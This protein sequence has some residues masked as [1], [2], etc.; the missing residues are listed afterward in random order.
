MSF[1]RS[2]ERAFIDSAKIA[3]AQTAARLDK[4]EERE[5]KLKETRDALI[6]EYGPE[7]VIKALGSVAEGP[8]EESS[9]IKLPP[10]TD[11]ADG[12]VPVAD[13][14]L[15]RV[16]ENIGLGDVAGLSRLLSRQQ[17]EQDIFDSEARQDQRRRKQLAE[18]RQYDEGQARESEERL[19]QA[20]SERYQNE[21]LDN[22]LRNLQTTT[23]ANQSAARAAGLPLPERSVAT[24]LSAQLAQLPSFRGGG[25][26]SD[27]GQSIAQDLD[28]AAAGQSAQLSQNIISQKETED[29]EAEALRQEVERKKFGSAIMQQVRS[30][31]FETEEQVVD[32]YQ[33]LG[34]EPET[35]MQYFRAAKASMPRDIGAE[36]FDA[37]LDSPMG[38]REGSGAEFYP[39]KSVQRQQVNANP[40]LRMFAE[41]I[42]LSG[43]Q[44][45]S[46]PK[47]RKLFEQQGVGDNAASSAAVLNF[48]QTGNLEAVNNL[49][50]EAQAQ[51]NAQINRL[52][53]SEEI[54]KIGNAAEWG[55]VAGTTSYASSDEFN[56]LWTE[57]KQVGIGKS[58]Q[59]P[60]WTVVP[61]LDDNNIH[62]DKMPFVAVPAPFNVL[63]RNLNASERKAMKQHAEGI[64][65]DFKAQH[66]KGELNTTKSGKQFWEGPPLA[67]SDGKDE[68][69]NPLN[70][71][72]VPP[73]L[74]EE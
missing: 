63:G 33:P 13:E 71:P 2:F 5:R 10:F 9:E 58:A 6:A 74:P 56:P 28:R 7:A 25:G 17:R 54:R 29:A 45:P 32:F 1:G 65:R 53:T 49:S 11:S 31:A 43:G 67:P 12:G 50:P 8:R 34:V 51:A 41:E 44:L 30:G 60:L 36:S 4:E 14:D 47:L 40:E 46:L 21:K 27:E 15:S 73:H 61:N 70:P 22:A 52:K 69:K 20:Q 68:K 42:I 64:T 37:S 66:S 23:T 3:S 48:L 57:R 24:D 55:Q 39:P 18:Q 62:D 19:R 72:T 59:I 16:I 26:F 35:A 38:Q